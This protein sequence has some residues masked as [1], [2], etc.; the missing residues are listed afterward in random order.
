MGDALDVMKKSM[1]MWENLA[2][3]ESKRGEDANLKII[4]E[5]MGKAADIAMQIAAVEDRRG[6]TEPITHNLSV[7]F[8]H[9]VGVAKCA[10]CG[11]VHV[12]RTNASAPQSLDE[13]RAKAE[14]RARVNAPRLLPAPARTP[15]ANDP[16]V[17][18][19][20]PRRTETVH[21]GNDY[22]TERGNSSRVLHG[23]IRSDELYNEK[24]SGKAL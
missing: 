16:V 8:V 22:A 17:I 18:D 10:K 15:K 20:T 13:L 5:A 12:D 9:G 24:R 11:H 6:T 23:S 7:S 21:D 1:A 4:A 2:A 19:V 14:T 3:V